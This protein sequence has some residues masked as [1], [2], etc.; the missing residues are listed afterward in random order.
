MNKLLAE[1]H[2]KEAFVYALSYAFERGAFFGMRTILIMY[3]IGASF[4]MDIA[5][6]SNLFAMLVLSLYFSKILGA[7]IG[8]LLL[9]SKRA[10]VLGGVIQTSGCIFLC[11][12]N[13]F[14]L[15]GGLIL[16]SIGSGLFTPNIKAHFGKLYLSKPRIM[17]SGFGIFAT[18]ANIGAF[19]GV[20]YIGLLGFEHE[21]NGFIL[22]SVMMAAGSL[23]P[24]FISESRDLEIPQFVIGAISKIKYLIF[25]M[26]GFILFGFITY[27]SDLGVFEIQTSFNPEDFWARAP[28][29]NI[30]T[31]TT[32][33][34]GLAAC[35]VWSYLFY[36]SLTKIII[37]FFFGSIGTIVLLFMEKPYDTLSLA[38]AGISIVF[39]ATGATHVHQGINSVVVKSVSPKFLGIAF[40]L[41]S[42]PG[43]LIHLAIF[44]V[45]PEIEFSGAEYL[46]YGSITFALVGI[47]LLIFRRKIVL[48]L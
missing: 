3:M 36:D 15:Y 2:P 32:G 5:V 19:F 39:I 47:I 23:I 8:D 28:L 22:A 44:P 24:L 31:I 1:R 30:D 27:F 33:I 43:L 20:Y 48:Q 40:A 41:L 35:F 12:E 9:G 4:K 46:L 38:I 11:F 29:K 21:Q 7:V 25:G 16:T 34:I 17:D 10:L 18:A 42:V 37:G 26:V 13:E 45:L 6:A 14:G